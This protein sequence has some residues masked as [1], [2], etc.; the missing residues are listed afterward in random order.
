MTSLEM[1]PVQTMKIELEQND[2]RGLQKTANEEIA[3]HRLREDLLALEKQNY[4]KIDSLPGFAGGGHGTL[5]VPGSGRPYLPEFEFKAEGGCTG[6]SHIEI[7]RFDI[8]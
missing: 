8:K 6:I 1:T 2:L 5:G 4:A 7:K 3:N